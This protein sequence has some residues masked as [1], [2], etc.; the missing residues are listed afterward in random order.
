MAYCSD[1][2]ILCFYFSFGRGIVTNILILFYSSIQTMPKDPD[3]LAA[4]THDLYVHN[5]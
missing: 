3:D 5:Y 4:K 2:L 1:F